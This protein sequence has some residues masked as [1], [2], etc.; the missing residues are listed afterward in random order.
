[1]WK[2]NGVVI[3]ELN[4]PF[5]R[6][7]YIEMTIEKSRWQFTGIEDA[8]V[9]LDG[10]NLLTAEFIGDD[11]LRTHALEILRTAESMGKPND[12]AAS[13]SE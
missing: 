10:T 5:L 6:G 1:M 3:R 11:L 13:L 12:G 4:G 7:H 8:C 9:V 2:A